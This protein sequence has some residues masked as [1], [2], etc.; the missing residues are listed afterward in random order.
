LKVTFQEAFFMSTIST[1][2]WIEEEFSGAIFP[3]PRLIKRFKIL[4]SELGAK[5]EAPINQAS[6]TSASTKGAYRFFNNDSVDDEMIIAPHIEATAIRCSNADEVVIAQDTTFLDYSS[7][8]SVKGLS[9]FQKKGK[10]FK[11]IA[12][13]TGLAMSGSGLPLGQ[14]YHHQWVREEK[15][16][17]TS[18]KR[19]MKPIEE[20]ESSRWLHCMAQSREI[21]DKKKIIHVGDREADIFEVFQFARSCKVDVVVR[22]AYDRI[23][24]EG[25]KLKDV[26]DSI[27]SKDYVSLEI[28]SNGSRKRRT[29]KLHIKYSLVTLDSCPT[30][31][32]T[33]R[34]EGRKDTVIWV[35]EAKE[36]DPPEDV[37]RL[38]WRL[39]T[40]LAVNSLDD[41]M[42]ILRYYRMRWN[43]ELFFKTLKSGC[44]IEDCRLETVKGLKRYNSL[45]S[46]FGW[47]LFWMA[48]I[49]GHHPDLSCEAFFKKSEW[50]AAWL[51]AHKSQIKNGLMKAKPPEKTP[52]LNEVIRWIANLGGLVGQSSKVKPGI[53]TMWRGWLSLVPAIEMYEMMCEN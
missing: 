40:T 1:S 34:N 48:F 36:K 12:L 43:V 6:L 22:S 5:P 23:V 27:K 16:I 26:L 51:M 39:L 32:T 30:G 3:D 15:V 52:K 9:S 7:H 50:Q 41:A 20:L 10:E 53:I 44:K 33:K 42:K 19:S 46:V 35:V 21:L 38:E 29:A 49:D 28:P 13:H 11:G 31:I 37:Q 4:A 25:G 45:I 18:H 14:L 8:E 47:R 24:T 2:S 17:E